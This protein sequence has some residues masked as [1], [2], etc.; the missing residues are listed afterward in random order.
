M[1]SR[2]NSF[3]TK[4]AQSAMAILAEQRALLSDGQSAESKQTRVPVRAARGTKTYDDNF[5]YAFSFYQPMIEYLDRKLLGLNVGGE[6][7]P[8]LRY[9]DEVG[10]EQVRK[11]SLKRRTRSDVGDRRVVGAVRSQTERNLNEAI[12]RAEEKDESQKDERRKVAKQYGYSRDAPNPSSSSTKSLSEGETSRVK[13]G[14][15]KSTS[16]SS[17]TPDNDDSIRKSIYYATRSLTSQDFNQQQHKDIQSRKFMTS[18]SHNESP[19]VGPSSS[20]AFST[21][22][23]F[24]FSTESYSSASPKRTT[25]RPLQKSRSF[26]AFTDKAL[27]DTEMTLR[28]DRLNKIRESIKSRRTLTSSSLLKD[29]LENKELG[30]ISYN[31]CTERESRPRRRN[32]HFSTADYDNEED[33]E[34]SIHSQFEVTRPLV[35]F[36]FDMSKKNDAVYWENMW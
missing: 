34:E 14:V 28:I 24:A 30:T 26:G 11:H 12:L 16:S 4:S 7:L 36:T 10:V 23:N 33:E 3:K 22:S 8:H 31:N 1:A 19:V 18:T 15:S 6:D 35:K 20:S 29:E 9:S 27:Q 25:T 13:L 2:S 5:D 32:V 17:L 21:S